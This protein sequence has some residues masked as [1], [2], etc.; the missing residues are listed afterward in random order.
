MNIVKK[1]YDFD[2][3]LKFKIELGEILLENWK[4]TS[5]GKSNINTIKL[6]VLPKA[7]YVPRRS[8]SMI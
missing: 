5:E 4:M 2:V 1:A 6:N 3:T 7:I 8:K